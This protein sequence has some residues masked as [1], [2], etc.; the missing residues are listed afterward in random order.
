MGASSAA[1]AVAVAARLEAEACLPS[2]LVRVAPEVFID[3]ES[4]MDLI[5][6]G[7]IGLRS[8]HIYLGTFYGEFVVYCVVSNHL[9]VR[10][11]LEAESIRR[12][13]EL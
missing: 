7:R 6:H 10:V 5:V 12:Y 11:D 8:H 4:E 2:P 3:L 13:L 1:V 9:D